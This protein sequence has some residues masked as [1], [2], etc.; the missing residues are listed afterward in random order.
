MWPSH[1]PYSS[2]CVSFLNGLI[3]M[4]IFVIGGSSS[5]AGCEFPLHW[6]GRWFQSGVGLLNVNKTNI[7]TKGECYESQGDKYVL[8]DKSDDCYR[9]VYYAC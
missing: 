3:I 6:A 2:F 7:E 4:C 9:S 8:Y 1:N 5:Q